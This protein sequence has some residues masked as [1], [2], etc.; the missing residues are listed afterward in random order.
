MRSLAM[1]LALATGLVTPDLI[2]SVRAVDDEAGKA[3]IKGLEGSYLVTGFVL[4]SDPKPQAALA[5][6][7]E[8]LRVLVIRGDRVTFPEYFGFDGQIGTLR[9]DSGKKPARFEMGGMKLDGQP[10]GFTGIYKMDG[11]VLTVCLGGDKPGE[12]PNEFKA[13]KGTLL[14]TFKK[15]PAK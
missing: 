1:L 7:D 10:L 15:R 14:L 5:A 3:A 4:G 2:T 8:K 6:L 11:D 9:L 12:P 13:V